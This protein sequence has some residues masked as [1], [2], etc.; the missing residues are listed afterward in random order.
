MATTIISKQ[1]FLPNRFFLSMNKSIICPIIQ[2]QKPGVFH[3]TI[4]I[5]P[6]LSPQINKL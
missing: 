4:S 2:K 1:V 5:S 6:I 3:F